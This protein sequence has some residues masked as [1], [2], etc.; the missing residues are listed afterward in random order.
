MEDGRWFEMEKQE[1]SHTC[2]TCFGGKTRGHRDRKYQNRKK[3]Y[4]KDK[5]GDALALLI[6]MLYLSTLSLHNKMKF[7]TV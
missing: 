3:T 5:T 4:M 7:K 6:V 1:M 2:E